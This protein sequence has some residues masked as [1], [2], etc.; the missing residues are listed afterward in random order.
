M[1]DF[2][3]MRIAIIALIAAFSAPTS[4]AQQIVGHYRSSATTTTG[5]VTYDLGDHSMSFAP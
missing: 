2:N 4:Y 3:I 1:L 5:A